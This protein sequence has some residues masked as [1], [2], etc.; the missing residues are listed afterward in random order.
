MITRIYL[1]FSYTSQTVLCAQLPDRQ[2]LGKKPGTFLRVY[3][4]R[5]VLL[6][7]IEVGTK[8]PMH[9]VFEL[10][11]YGER[12]PLRRFSHPELPAPSDRSKYY[13]DAVL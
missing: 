6:R 9:Y 7:C 4:T 12:P 8:T 13:E 5:C 1:V 11:T 10:L 3:R 2:Q